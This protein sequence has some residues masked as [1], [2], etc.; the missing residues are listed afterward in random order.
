[1]C[2]DGGI[3]E[4]ALKYQKEIVDL[5]SEVRYHRALKEAFEE[6]VQIMETEENEEIVRLRKEIDR[7]KSGG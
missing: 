6:R 5:K 3:C 7:V 2:K 1:M 4:C